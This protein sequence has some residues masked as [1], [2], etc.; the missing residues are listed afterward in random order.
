MS[1]ATLFHCHGA[2]SVSL[3]HFVPDVDINLLT[4]RRQCI[5]S[6]TLNYEHYAFRAIRELCA[7]FTSTTLH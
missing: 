3:S 5:F 7:F 2:D 4:D 1:L 6:T